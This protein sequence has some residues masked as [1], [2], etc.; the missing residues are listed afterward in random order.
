[1][2]YKSGQVPQQGD[3]VMGPIDG[4]TVR[5]VVVRV[6]PPD[7]IVVERR[8]AYEVSAQ[9]RR[10]AGAVAL[11]VVHDEV[12]SPDFDL[13]YRRPDASVPAPAPLPAKKRAGAK[14]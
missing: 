12:A 2:T 4:A 8:A 3:S 9:K 6:L 1:M 14:A 10:A 11:Q 5:G 13:V 7:K